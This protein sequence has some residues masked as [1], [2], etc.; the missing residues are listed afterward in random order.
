MITTLFLLFISLIFSNEIE[1]YFINET[2]SKMQFKFNFK[3]IQNSKVGCAKRIQTLN[4]LEHSLQL[5][6]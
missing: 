6:T 4:I 1:K 3:N 5:K 2:S